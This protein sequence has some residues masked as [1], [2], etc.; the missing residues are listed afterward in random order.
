MSLEIRVLNAIKSYKG[1][2]KKSRW[3]SL[4]NYQKENTHRET[5]I[6]AVSDG[7]QRKRENRNTTE[8]VSNQACITA[9]NTFSA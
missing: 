2:N 8:E 9:E 7:K 5:A 3:I 1:N 6:R 4:P